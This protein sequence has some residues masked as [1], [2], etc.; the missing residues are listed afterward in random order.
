MILYGYPIPD[1]VLIKEQCLILMKILDIGS[2]VISIWNEAN[3]VQKN[4]VEYRQN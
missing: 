1:A 4:E 3:E 2:I